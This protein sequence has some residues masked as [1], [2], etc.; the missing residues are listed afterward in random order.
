MRLENLTNGH[1]LV[2]K[3]KLWLG[4]LFVGAKAPDMVRIMYYRPRF[5]GKTM[6]ILT[7]SVMRGPSEWTVGERELFAAFVSAK[8]RCR[9]CS[10]AHTAIAVRAMPQ[11]I[12]K[13]TLEGDEYP[14]ALRPKVRTI[15]P[16]LE[17]LTVAPDNISAGD[18]F[19]LRSAGLSDAAIAD[20]AYVCMLFC[21]YNRLAD[22]LDC[23][24]MEPG[25]L[26]AVSKRLLEKGYDL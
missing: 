20:A 23:A 6:G 25:Q 10:Q 1:A 13:A 9:F 16:F 14:E 11:E 8:N 22:S 5:F 21:T 17:K 24:L 2:Q 18:L 7:Q 19:P 26:D 3:L 15:L 12:V 4:P